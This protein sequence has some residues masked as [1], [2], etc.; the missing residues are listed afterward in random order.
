VSA[1]TFTTDKKRLEEHFRKNPV[2]FAY[3]LG[4]L[5]DFY[6]HD[7]Q[8]GVMYGRTTHIDEAVLIY[9]RGDIPTVL[10]F[11][12]GDRFG[13]LLD[14]MAT[15]LPRKFYC[16]FQEQSRARLAGLYSETGLGSHRK[17]KLEDFRPLSLEGHAAHI[18]RL[19]SSYREQLR[20]L[21][22]SVYPGNY[23]DDRMLTTGK[24][25]G[26][27]VE[28]KVLAVSG[29]HVYSPEYKI[30]VLGNIVTSPACRNLGY[31]SL[32][33]SRLCEE[34][35]SENCTVCLNVKDDNVSAILVYEKLGFATV[36]RYEESLFSL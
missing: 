32:L 30:A 27:L 28:D 33:T 4:D 22:K 11:G 7:C 9:H 35:V 18:Q 13:E 24:Y 20:D 26:F 15:L 16:H 31:A 36:C 23:F 25:F 3:H 17:M 29:V 2:L 34:L 5:D 19:N 1:L 14:E 12:I 10:A 8:W 6:F 21:Y